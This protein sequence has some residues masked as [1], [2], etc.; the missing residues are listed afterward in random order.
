MINCRGTGGLR[1]G[2]RWS[3]AKLVLREMLVTGRGE[4]G[5]NQSNPVK[6]G[7]SQLD[8]ESTR[9]KTG[10][11][12]GKE[13]AGESK[14]M[15]SKVKG[16]GGGR[17]QQVEGGGTSPAA[18]SGGSDHLQE[19]G[20][21]WRPS[22]HILYHSSYCW[23]LYIFFQSAFIGWFKVAKGGNGGLEMGSAPLL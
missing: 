6:E 14:V 8:R 4:D 21:R 7:V 9:R 13:V 19:N 20:N 11:G 18:G 22:L 16:A 2:N 12:A 3:A 23:A 5:G 17:E 1:K 10:G 15:D